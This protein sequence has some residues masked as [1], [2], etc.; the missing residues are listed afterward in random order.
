MN[1]HV[2]SS[3]LHGFFP[4]T[5]PKDVVY[6][7]TGVGVRGKV[8]EINI[9]CSNQPKMGPLLSNIPEYKPPL[10]IPHFS[11]CYVMVCC[12]TVCRGECVLMCSRGIT[13]MSTNPAVYAIHGHSMVR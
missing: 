4:H 5:G 11:R 8:V 9:T 1:T 2:S 6:L 13:P 3:R 12:P 7:V 10:T